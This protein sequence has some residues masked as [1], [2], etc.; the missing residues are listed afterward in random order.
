MTAA[1]A[2]RAYMKE[3]RRRNPD[4][5]RANSK[6]Y[7]ERKAQAADAAQKAKKEGKL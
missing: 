1:E 2:K 4:K 7:W 5:V 3:W 6:R